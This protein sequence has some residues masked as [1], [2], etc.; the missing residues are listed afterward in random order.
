M[1]WKKYIILK[2]LINYFHVILLKKYYRSSSENNSKPVHQ[3]IYNQSHFFD[4]DFL[5][6]RRTIGK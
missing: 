1:T 4:K 2:K 5:F 6:E 3:P